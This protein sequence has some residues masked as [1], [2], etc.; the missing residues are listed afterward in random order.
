MNKENKSGSIRPLHVALSACIIGV[1]ALSIGLHGSISNLKSSAD[2]A[3]NG[4][5]E[6]PDATYE[7]ALP[8][9]TTPTE[10]AIQNAS[11]VYPTVSSDVQELDDSLILANYAVLVDLGSNQIIAQ[12]NPDT[13]LFPA[14]MSKIMTLIV[15][16]EHLS[17]LDTTFTMTT[18]IIN[19]LVVEGAA[20]AGFEDGEKVTVR[21]LLYGCGL[22]SGAEATMAL[23]VLVSGTEGD[24]VALMNQKAQELGLVNTHFSN[25]T[26]LHDEDH[27]TTATDLAMI[28]EYAMQNEDLKTI[29]STYQYTTS[30]TDVHPEGILLEST[31]F[32]KM[33]GNEVE[34]LT[35][36]A[37]K[38]GFTDEAGYCLV[39]Y[40]EDGEGRG[41]ICVAAKSQGR[42]G[43]VYDTLNIYGTIDGG[44]YAPT[45]TEAPTEAPTAAPAEE[46]Q[47][48]QEEVQEDVQEEQVQEEE[49]QAPVVEETQAPVVE[50][51]QAQVVDDAPAENNDG[52]QE[53]NQKK[54]RDIYSPVESAA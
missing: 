47:V 6:L 30:S 29:L 27:Y 18:D 10:E 28:M 40:A 8:Q 16:L 38:T 46:Q 12:R 45:T 23:A 34:G 19:P 3:V 37:G 9:D 44:Y 7:T 54:E 21:D 22:P 32:E 25:C 39:S 50:E 17:D 52:V 35:I 43:A 31:T 1:A 48:V 20:L 5:A 26:G 53:N 42:K 24:F 36:T 15:A 49:Q 51:T 41:Y 11:L 13:K 33:Y 4:V 2:S 14:S